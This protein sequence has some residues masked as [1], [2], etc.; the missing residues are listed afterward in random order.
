MHGLKALKKWMSEDE[1]IARSVGEGEMI[2]KC[3]SLLRLPTIEEEVKDQCLMGS[4]EEEKERGRN[5]GVSITEKNGILGIV[6]EVVEGG[7]WRGE[8]GELEE[9]VSRLEEEGEKKWRERKGKKEERGKN[10][11]MLW[12]E[13]KR[14]AHD[15]L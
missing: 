3:V 7:G 15:G 5:E 6:L 11:Y 13:M 14:L 9:V 10:S 4:E 1:S 12:R 2:E 8:Y